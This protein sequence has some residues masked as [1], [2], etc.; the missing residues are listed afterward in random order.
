MTQ[1][2]LAADH[3]YI[4]I[5][6][7]L[8]SGLDAYLWWYA[9]SPYIGFQSFDG[10]S[11]DPSVDITGDHDADG[12]FLKVDGIVS[13]KKTGEAIE[14]QFTDD[15]R[16]LWKITKA[17]LRKNVQQKVYESIRNVELNN[18]S[19]H[20]WNIWSATWKWSPDNDGKVLQWWKVL[21][22]GNLT[23]Q[24]IVLTENNN[25][26]WNKTLVVEWWDIYVSG[27]LRG[28]GLLGLVAIRKGNHGWNIYI[29]PSVTDVHA[30]MYADR[31]VI[32][33]DGTNELD[34]GT[35]DQNL[36]NQL[37]I[38]GSIFSENTIGGSLT[39]TCPYYTASCNDNISKKYDL[40]LLRRYILVSE[41][42]GDGNPT[43]VQ[44]P[45]FWGAESYMWNEFDHDTEAQRPGYR[46]F[47]L[48]IEYNPA[49]QQT[50]PPFF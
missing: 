33:Y 44:Y 26:E 41:V 2:F 32:S 50:P 6:T 10:I 30:V 16:V 31:S 23:W 24:D 21:Y 13:S 11:L 4:C 12:R 34:G 36:A 48:I 20:I 15:V 43:W 3:A 17:T 22:F 47:P 7:D 38:Y 9:Y 40:N 28:E 42:D 5:P 25:I 49:I 27:N 45:Q 19:L 14:D 29:N 37:Y 39:T 18:G 1:A 46:K 8:T 35:E